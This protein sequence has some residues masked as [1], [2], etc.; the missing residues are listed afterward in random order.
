MSIAV[1]KQSVGSGLVLTSECCSKP[2]MRES[3]AYRPIFKPPPPTQPAERQEPSRTKHSNT[4]LGHEKAASKGLARPVPQ[5]CAKKNEK[6]RVAR[7]ARS[8]NEHY[9]N[10]V[11]PAR[12]RSKSKL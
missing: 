3:Q 7:V 1:C 2:S 11:H 8:P 10:P 12:T 9:K 5:V 6:H 4:L